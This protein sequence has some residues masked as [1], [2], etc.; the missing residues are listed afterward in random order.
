MSKTP[1]SNP[2]KL[3]T[4]TKM[5]GNDLNKYTVVKD[6]NTKKWELFK[7]LRP[8]PDKH[9]SSLPVDTKLPGNDGFMYVVT[10]RSDKTKYWKKTDELV[11]IK[12]QTK[13]KQIMWTKPGKN[14]PGKGPITI[15]I[16]EIYVG[17]TGVYMVVRMNITE[18]FY[19]TLLKKPKYIVNKSS[20]GNA[21]IF[22]KKFPV[23]SYISLGYHG[24]DGAQTGVLDITNLTESD[25][26]DIDN[27]EEWTK[28]YF[29][30]SGRSHSW[31]DRNMLP[32]VRDQISD[33]ILFVGE[34][35]GGD[36]GADVLVHYNT[37]KEIDG[38]IIDNNTIST[39]DTS[40]IPIK[41][42]SRKKRRR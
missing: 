19:G 6:G 15:S 7:G 20:I 9:A 37:Q 39:G 35:H 24:N 12:E 10:K 38:L 32:L 34:T 28:L 4:G 2:A 41:K 27:M 42:S 26:S 25:I 29:P 30:K 23:K 18:E 3:P 8:S 40:D 13:E 16:G 21:Y 31:E 36:V 1:N 5:R 17:I 14:T 33:R 11:P 22:G